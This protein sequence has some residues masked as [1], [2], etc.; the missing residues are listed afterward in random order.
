MG[1]VEWI[2]LAQD[3]DRWQAVV[4]VVMNLRAQATRSYLCHNLTEFLCFSVSSTRP[5]SCT[6]K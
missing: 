2:Q 3:W 6:V 1:G 4:N 5:V